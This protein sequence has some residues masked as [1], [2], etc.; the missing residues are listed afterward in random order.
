[1]VI[2]RQRLYF[3]RLW[4]VAVCSMR[5]CCWLYYL[6]VLY[7]EEH[8]QHKAGCYLCQCL[9]IQSTF[10]HRVNTWKC[11][12][13]HGCSSTAHSVYACSQRIRWHNTKR[14][15]I[16]LVCPH[17]NLSCDLCFGTILTPQWTSCY[18]SIAWKWELSIFL[19]SSMEVPVAYVC[20]CDIWCGFR[21]N[22][23]ICYYYL[24]QLVSS[25]AS[26]APCRIEVF[27]CCDISKLMEP[28]N[29]Y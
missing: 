3:R 1:M 13:T 19:V 28:V 8:G 9:A 7:A 2:T 25:D 11:R 23:L 27:V 21:V 18:T 29:P 22:V 4:Q 5:Y 15:N 10:S 14:C 26:I 17:E 16:R 12:V 6:S 24:L 20:K